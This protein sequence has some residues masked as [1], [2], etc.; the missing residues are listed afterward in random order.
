MSERAAGTGEME[1]GNEP[2]KPSLPAGDRTEL[3][4]AR[5]RLLTEVVGTP[6]PV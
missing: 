1:T 4:A 2:V 6:K 5:L 3:A